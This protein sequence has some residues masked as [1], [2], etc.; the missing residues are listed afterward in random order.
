MTTPPD[1]EIAQALKDYK[2]IAI[3]GL[4]PE[5][6]R[7]SYE[8]GHYLI[9]RGY[10]VVGVRPGGHG[11][12]LDK[13]VYERLADIPGPLEII[14]V[15]RRSDA[16]AGV[17]DEVLAEMDRRMPADRPKLL[18]LQEGVTDPKAE[19]RA[20]QRGLLVVSNRCILKEHARLLRE[21]RV[22]E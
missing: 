2:R 21:T 18:W 13:P 1:A 17:V 10:D 9:A 19:A 15:F 20:R 16:I 7:P 11:P 3:L 12:V 6:S 4:S 5:P 14:D 22:S 8:V